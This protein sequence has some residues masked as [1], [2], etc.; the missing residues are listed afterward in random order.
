MSSWNY[1]VVRKNVYM[2]KTIAPEVQFGIHETYYNGKD[3]P[4]AITTD[5]MSPYGGTLD[6]LKSDLEKMVVALE[7]PV[8]NW[9]DFKN[10]EVEESVDAKAISGSDR[11]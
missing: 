10:K 11:E 1:R 6:E 2:G 3:E 4:T 9:E 7:K 5:H 8:L